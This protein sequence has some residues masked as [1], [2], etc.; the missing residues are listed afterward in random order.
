M[1]IFSV[2][3]LQK[4]RNWTF[5]IRCYFTWKLELVSNIFLI[6]VASP[7][8]FVYDFSKKIY[9]VLYS[10]NQSSF[11]VLFHLLLEIL[12]NTCIVII[13]WPICDVKNFEI[14]L[15]I[16]SFFHKILKFVLKILKALS[17]IFGH[18]E[19]QLD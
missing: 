18:E 5:P 8:H 16:K 4:K 10:N 7:P 15:L 12:H 11:I 17:W 19:K 14:S 2:K 1:N 13:C 6:I 3:N 9:L